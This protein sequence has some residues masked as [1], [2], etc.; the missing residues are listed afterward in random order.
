ML[1]P[2]IAFS[3]HQGQDASRTLPLL[4]LLVLLLRLA[5]AALAAR[6]LADGGPP[7]DG[8]ALACCAPG[9]GRYRPMPCLRF[10]LDPSPTL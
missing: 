4:L 1:T 7:G 8:E 9:N 3:Q 5:L 2:T 6:A 10:T